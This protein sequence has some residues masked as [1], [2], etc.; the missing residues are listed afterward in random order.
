MSNH[1]TAHRARTF[2][3]KARVD[4]SVGFQC[5]APPSSITMVGATALPVGYALAA[6]F[7]DPTDWSINPD[8]TCYF[9]RRV[10]GPTHHDA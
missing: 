2:N 6:E 1:K 5:D 9:E 3:T 7:R 4:E 8:A 10:V